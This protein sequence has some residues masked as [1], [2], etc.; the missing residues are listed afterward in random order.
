[1]TGEN[2][3]EKQSGKN[4]EFSHSRLQCLST[5]QQRQRSSFIKMMQGTMFNYF[6]R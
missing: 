5:A 2:G 3:G 1:M 4:R 6:S